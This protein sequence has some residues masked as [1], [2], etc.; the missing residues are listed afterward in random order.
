M[1][2]VVA[3]QG[4]AT[5]EG[6]AVDWAGG[7]LYW[8]ES[9]L[10][11]IEVARL[12]GRHRRTLL[13]GGMEAPRALALDPAEGLLF[14]SDWEQAAPR[15]ERASMA[16]R[17][18]RALVRVDALSGGAWPNGVALDPRPRRLYWIDARSDSIHTTDYDGNDYREVLRGHEALAHPFA[19][20]V[21]EGHVYWTDWRTNS[22]VRAD[23]WTGAG[24][25]VLQRTLT[26]PFD[27]KVSLDLA[28][29]LLAYTKNVAICTGTDRRRK[30]VSRIFRR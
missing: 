18:R 20:T 11:Q 9:R 15:I 7:N 17:G 5:A 19:L 27:L 1:K 16:G 14:W 23:K 13:A 10:H 4:L 25:T 29:R 26:Q 30:P 22:V 12:D 6:L 2:A 28:Y 24:V 21:F 3:W 8:V